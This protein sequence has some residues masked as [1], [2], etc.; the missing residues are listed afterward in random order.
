MKRHRN[1]LK[2][3]IRLNPYLPYLTTNTRSENV[4]LGK[5]TLSSAIYLARIALSH[6]LKHPEL[7]SIELG[8][9]YTVEDTN[10]RALET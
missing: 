2:D 8:S 6:L 4:G 10:L 7:T 9:G 3:S 1:G 5:A